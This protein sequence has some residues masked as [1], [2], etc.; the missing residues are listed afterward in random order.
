MRLCATVRAVIVAR[1]PCDRSLVAAVI[2]KNTV[3]E[4]PC[5]AVSA[6]IKYMWVRLS[7]MLDT[8]VAQKRVQ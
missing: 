1:V 4:H 2:R 6:E 8:S 5:E 7:V 3:C